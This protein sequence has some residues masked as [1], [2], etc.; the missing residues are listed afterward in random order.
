MRGFLWVI[1][2]CVYRG[3][4]HE[5]KPTQALLK[6][7]AKA[8]Q[9]TSQRLIETDRKVAE[10]ENS[11]GYARWQVIDW[12]LKMLRYNLE[13]GEGMTQ[14]SQNLKPTFNTSRYDVLAKLL[15]V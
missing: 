1:I 14:S 12:N 15:L 9:P 6:P 4:H 8:K 5:L 13:T 2:T 7:K 10:N 3:Q 11:S